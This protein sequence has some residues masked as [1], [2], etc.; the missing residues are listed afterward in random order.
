MFTEENES[1]TCVHGQ[2]ENT[3]EI[4]GIACECKPDR[5]WRK[6]I[7]RNHDIRND[8]EIDQNKTD[9]KRKKKEE[10]E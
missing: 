4:N 7:V 3:N 10:K 5:R 9:R 2:C 1:N 8:F 6:K